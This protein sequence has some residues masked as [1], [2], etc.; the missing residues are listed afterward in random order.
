MYCKF[1]SDDAG[2]SGTGTCTPLGTAGQ[3]CNADDDW[4]DCAD[5][6]VCGTD[7]TCAV[8]QYVALGASCD[9]NAVV[10]LNSDCTLPNTQDAS[11]TG[12]CTAFAADGASC[13]SGQTC[14]FNANCV[15]GTCSTAGTVCN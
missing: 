5:G 8:V 3:P 6:L 12:V 14:A 15:A 10:C 4:N 9:G 1:A 2:T 11:A 13:Q 7:G